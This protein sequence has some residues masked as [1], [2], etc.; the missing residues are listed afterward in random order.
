MYNKIS[1][2]VILLLSLCLGFFSS[3]DDDDDDKVAKPLINLHEVGSDDSKTVMAGTDLHLDAEITA[4]GIIKNIAIEIHQEEGGSFKIEKSYSGDKYAV[5]N[6]HFHEHLD[7]PAEAPAGSYH[8]HLTVTDQLGQTA[9]AESE[10]KIEAAPANIKIEGL[11][12]G[13]GHDFPDNKIGYI[14][15]APVVEVALIEAE[16]GVDKIYVELHGEGGDT[17]FELD[18]T[19]VMAGETKLEGFHKHISIPEDAPAGD[20][21]LHLKVF[22]KN[23]KTLEKALHVELKEAGIEVSDLEI[24]HDNIASADNIHT[25][26]KVVAADPLTSIRVRVY[27]ADAPTVYFVNETL[28]DDFASGSVKEYTYHKHLKAMDATPG[29]YLVNIRINDSKGASKTIIQKITLTRN[30]D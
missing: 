16:S 12:F 9:V 15:T 10:L 3:C 23:G 24:G 28:T 22:D 27:Q 7:I 20:Y 29:E 2:G 30:E 6:V 14:G 5:R 11:I 13:A 26:F 1:L 18:T 17:P 8:L 19:F 25:E 21:H 4:D